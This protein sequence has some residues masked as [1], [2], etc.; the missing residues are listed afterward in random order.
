MNYFEFYPGDYMRDTAD[1]SPTE[2]GCYLLLMCSYYSTERALPSEYDALYRISHAHSKIEQVA[3][4]SV[5]ERYFSIGDDG[6]RH[7]LR[8]DQEIAK[9]QPR[10]RA[11]RENGGKGGRPRNLKYEPTGNPPETQQKPSGLPVANPAETQPGE[12]LHAPCSI[13]Q[14]LE[15]HT[16]TSVSVDAALP[17]AQCPHVE[18][19]AAYHELLPALS[20]VREWTPARQ[21]LLRK[22][23]KE[24]PER[25]SLNW[26]REFFTYVG[27]S[28]FLMGRANTPG[29]EPF[30]CDI[31]W[32]LRPSNFVKV[33]E[34]KYENRRAA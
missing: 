5:V 32:L 12:A 17:A 21:Q 23:W 4:R 7:N 11:A 16:E 14:A 33:I 26:W 34:G 27:R 18:I 1:L 8:A 6:L 30:Q 9:A 19:V 31:E 10:I 22:R 20:R 28:D 24:K 29:R 25:Q 13:P 3:L 2:H 15:E